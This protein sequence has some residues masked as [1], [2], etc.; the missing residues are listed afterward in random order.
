MNDERVQSYATAFYE[1]AFE[2]WLNALDAAAASLARNPGL[3]ERLEDLQADFAARQRLLDGV[4]SRDVDAS[5]HNLLY[6][7]LQR[8]DLSLLPQISEAL[9]QLVRKAETGPVP[10]E[11]V[12]AMPL[13]DDQRKALESRLAAQYGPALVYD[14]QVDPAILGGMIVRVGDQLIDGS[15][16]TRLAAM[17]QTLGVRTAE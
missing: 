1:A 11:I 12:T 3:M 15:I 6:T 13:P 9:R 8:G 14:Y 4:A 7:L 10:V 16:A 5:V 17:K 2:R